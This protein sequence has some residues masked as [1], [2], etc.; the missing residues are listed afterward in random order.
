VCVIR[1]GDYEFYPIVNSQLIAL[2]GRNMHAREKFC[3]AMLC[4]VY[5]SSQCKMATR[6]SARYREADM[7]RTAGPIGLCV[8]IVNSE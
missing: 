2:C 8:M 7:L 6:C 3:V 4:N 1:L 5:V